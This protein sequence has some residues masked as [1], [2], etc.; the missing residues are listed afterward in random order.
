MGNRE[1]YSPKHAQHAITLEMYDAKS[2]TTKFVP[3]SF[4]SQD[5]QFIP[6]PLT[7]A[8]P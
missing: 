4:A 2:R 1:N 6:E 5:E 7:V 8:Q 3:V